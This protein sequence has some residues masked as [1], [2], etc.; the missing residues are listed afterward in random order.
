MK[1]IFIL[2]LSVLALFLSG[3]A[4]PCPYWRTDYGCAQK[5]G[6]ESG[7]PLL[8][9]ITA[10]NCS[11]CE[12]NWCRIFSRKEFLAEVSKNLVPVYLS[13]PYQD[14]SDACSALRTKY[15]ASQSPSLLILDSGGE[16]IAT[17]PF[18]YQDSEKC[19]ESI[20]ALL[21]NK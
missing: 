15:D 19:L 7:K 13:C 10:P 18:P 8:V 2:T 14:P 1:N 12:S 21:N 3:C 20:R 11:A 9:L 16:M 4:A 17:V 6:L 5:E